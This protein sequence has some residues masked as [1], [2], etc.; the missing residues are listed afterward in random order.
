M[1]KLK[2]REIVICQSY[3]VGNCRIM[4]RASV[5]LSHALM[6]F[7]WPLALHLLFEWFC[8]KLVFSAWR[9]LSWLAAH[10]CSEKLSCLFSFSLLRYRECHTKWQKLLSLG[11]SFFCFIICTFCVFCIC[12]I[13]NSSRSLLLAL[14]SVT[15]ERVIDRPPRFKRRV[16]WAGGPGTVPSS[17]VQEP[18]TFFPE[19]S[20]GL[21][22][23]L[24][25]T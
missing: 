10:Q 5:S 25:D 17:Q 1:R 8:L 22:R 18:H 14:A 9:A 4:V 13:W 20:L 16:S 7:F 21:T 3:K 24:H 19:V 6:P 23:Q 12:T 11:V 15:M 2:L